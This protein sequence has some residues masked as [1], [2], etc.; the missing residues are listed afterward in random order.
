VLN[1]LQIPLKL[2]FDFKE[3]LKTGIFIK[4]FTKVYK[5]YKKNN[6]NQIYK[7]LINYIYK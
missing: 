7:K 4:I 5:N 6:I 3:R 2:I 1:G